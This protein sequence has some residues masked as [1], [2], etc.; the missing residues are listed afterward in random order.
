MRDV[1]F[2][3]EEVEQIQPLLA[4]Y[5]KDG[6]IQGVKYGQI[7]TVLVNAVKEQQAQIEDQN[8]RIRRQQVQMDEQ[9]KLITALKAI[10]C[11]KSR[12]AAVC[13]AK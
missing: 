2:A 13:G 12:A 6:Q 4:T 1:G 9:Q 3:A 5:N 7:T 8:K 10:V 11:R